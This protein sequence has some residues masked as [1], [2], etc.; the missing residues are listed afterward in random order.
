MFN[1][2]F[3]SIFGKQ[4]TIGE[5]MNIDEGRQNKA[6]Q[7]FVRL[8]KTYH[9]LKK[10]GIID[11]FKSFFTGETLINVYYVIFKLEVTSE[12]GNK[13]NVFIRV[14]PDFNLNN[15][16]N[17]EVKIYCN[18]A[19]FKYRSSYLLNKRNSLFLNDKIKI[20]LGQALTDAP[21]GKS[22]TTLLCKHSY[23]ALMWL[24]TNYSNI[25]KTI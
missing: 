15:W 18:C 17:N 11:R 6:S 25:M 12:T 21:K 16:V 20:S 5:L 13:Y 1:G 10:E 23:A 22:K 8:V 14:N 9:E 19:D 4:Y 3:N 24:I 7:C 2:L